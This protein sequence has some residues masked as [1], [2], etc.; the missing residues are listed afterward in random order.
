MNIT[1]VSIIAAA[2]ITSITFSA[3]GNSADST[4]NKK[5]YSVPKVG[6][7]KPMNN[8]DFK[9]ATAKFSNGY[10]LNATWGVGSAATHKIGDDS[11]TFY[12][13][14]DRGVNI[15]CKNDKK[16]VGIDI[17]EKGKIFTYPTFT[18]TIIKFKIDS[19]DV[20]V[21]EVITLKD[22][23][24]NDM[25]GVSNPLSN[26]SEKAYNIDGSTLTYDVNGLDAEALAVMKDGSFW[27]A[28]EYAPS[29]AHFDAKGKII[30]RLIPKG[31][32]GLES[33]NY[34]V[35]DVLPQIISKRHENRGI[36]SI[37]VSPDEKSLYFSLQ[38]P[39]D[40]PSYG[41]T[42][43][44]RLYKVN[45]SDYS[46]IKEYLYVESQPQEF[47]K[48]NATKKRKQKD[49]KV[50]EMTALDNDILMVLERVSATTKLFKVDL[51]DAISVPADKSTNLE[52]DASG[53]IP[54][55]KVKVFDTD[56]QSGYPNKIEG[57][58]NLGNGKFLLI[59]DNDFGIEGD[60]TVA[61]IATINNL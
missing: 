32:T 28:E 11:D 20:V 37:A 7:R 41:D 23:K 19:Q 8:I 56:S 59:N 14:T 44:V 1:K 26:F 4:G 38:S 39:L 57:I 25:T 34:T 36:E 43:N 46:D 17:C 27:I 58:A 52:T 51:R 16:T 12:T 5:S 35:K 40:N 48:D 15:K 61:K 33:A 53:V 21:R 49:V 9:L 47:I 55:S 24:G 3:C 6:E 22:A 10:E 45:L 60:K 13:L 30:E 18:P 42:P 50:S 31:V 29:I 54:V 2:V